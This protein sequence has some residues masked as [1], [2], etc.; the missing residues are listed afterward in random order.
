MPALPYSAVAFI[1]YSTRW[2]VIGL[3]SL[4]L[5][6]AADPVV[7]PATAALDQV[8]A[9]N[10]V[11]REIAREAAAW[12]QERQRLEA[13]IAATTAD[14]ARSERDALAA[15]NAR[16]AARQRVAA[17][18]GSSDLEALRARL[19]QAGVRWNAVLA[20]LAAT[21][22]PGVVPQARAEDDAFDGAVKALDAAERAAGGVA[23]E[24]VTGIR[25]GQPAAVKMLRI[26]GAAA[27]WVALDGSAAG[28]VT[29]KSGGLELQAVPGE[30][31]RL[32][33]A[34][35]LAQAEGRS[36]PSVVLL[37]GVQP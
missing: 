33:I 1:R 8:R 5:V 7:D 36:G 21:L 31:E 16:D 26:A 28:T 27:W 32:A 10:Q 11:R 23:V 2:T 6:S 24:V 29:M 35:A 3:L 13:L 17:L 34:A 20:Q 18:A 19:A 22:P 15:E 12:T 37:P 25:D 9:A 14:T 4:G 30:P